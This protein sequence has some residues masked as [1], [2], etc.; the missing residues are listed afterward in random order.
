MESYSKSYNFIIL[1]QILIEC[2]YWYLAPLKKS[3]EKNEEYIG[4]L[5]LLPLAEYVVTTGLGSN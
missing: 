4:R 1:F 3:H 2:S 5:T